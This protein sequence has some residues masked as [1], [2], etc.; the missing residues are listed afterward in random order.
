[1]KSTVFLKTKFV[2]QNIKWFYLYSELNKRLINIYKVGKKNNDKNSPRKRR[3][4][5]MSNSKDFAG[6]VN[7]LGKCFLIIIKNIGNQ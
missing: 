3:V 7:R 1:M 6:I 2:K 4:F 5:L